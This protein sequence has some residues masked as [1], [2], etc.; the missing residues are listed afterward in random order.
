MNLQ[1]FKANTR[2]AD[3]SAVSHGAH[4][5]RVFLPALGRV[6]TAN[7]FIHANL[8]LARPYGIETRPVFSLFFLRPMNEGNH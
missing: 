6:G 1:H 4:R 5:A 2:S 7:R 3:L 8:G